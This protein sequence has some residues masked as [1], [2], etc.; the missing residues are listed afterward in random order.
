[1]SNIFD[2][3]KTMAFQEKSAWVM[4]IA[5]L[6]AGGIYFGVVGQLSSGAGQLVPPNVPFVTGYTIVLVIA[7]VL[8]HIVVAAMSPSEAN[9]DLDERDRKIQTRAEAI[10]GYV[11]GFGVIACLG[12]YLWMREGDVLFYG[13]LLFLML[14]QLVEYAL[15]IWFYRTAI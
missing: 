7:A 15:K 9:A 11:L 4:S 10:S 6:V 5:L 12:Y 2:M 8:G 3:E 14:S 13:I 1:M